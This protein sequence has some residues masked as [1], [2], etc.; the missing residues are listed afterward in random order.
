MKSKVA[1]LAG[2]SGLIGKELLVLLL[3]APIYSKVIV[4]VRRPLD[5]SHQKLEQ[6]I[7][8]FEMIN[9]DD[10]LIDHVFCTLGTTIKRAGS[11]DAFRHIDQQ[12]A[13]NVAKA[14]KQN[15][16]EL[17]TIVTAMGAN[18][19]SIFFYNQVKGDVEAELQQMDYKYLGVFRP[20]MLVGYR[21]KKRFAEQIGTILMRIFDFMIPANYKIIH[22]NK[23]A[24]A[25]FDYAKKPIKGLFVCSSAAMLNKKNSP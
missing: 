15:G 9:L 5:I 12:Y 13:V 21:D 4:L 10:L 17:F 22:V 14:A 3:A 11:K 6:R 8:D 1:L 24:S 25:M 7:V 18:S 2:A 16:A 19:E 20:S 23:V